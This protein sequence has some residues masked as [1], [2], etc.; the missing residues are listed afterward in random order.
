MVTRGTVDRPA[1]GEEYELPGEQQHIDSLIRQLRAKMERDYAAGRVL[2]DAHPKM[3]A[4]VRGEFTIEPILPEDLRV[5]LFAQPRTYP[6]WIR[7]SNASG[8]VAP[9]AKGDIRGVG[10]K[11]MDVAGPKLQVERPDEA[12][13]DFLL[14]SEDRFVTKDVAQF[15]GLVAALTGGPLQI[16][17][18]FLCHPRAARNLW[19]SLKPCSQPLDIRYFSVAPYAWGSSAVKYSITPHDTGDTLT[20]D[21]KAPDFL[22]AAMIERLGRD[23]A[24]FDFSVQL[25]LDPVAMPIE[26]PGVR[27]DETRS[28]FRMVATLTIPSQQFDTPA[29][30]EFGDNLSFNPWRCVAAH[31][32]LGGISRA[33]RQV[34]QALSVFRHQRNQAPRAEPTLGDKDWNAR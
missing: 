1:L 23:G 22:R 25:Q 31:R 11:L 24:A 19:V 29:R 20:P 13:H 33:R 6:A 16:V 17:W 7:F 21:K 28:P 30:R 8:T 15:D 2:R 34:Y 3:H 32:P 5:G 10:I 18:F 26:D 14:I 9:D 4:C 27:W 12:T